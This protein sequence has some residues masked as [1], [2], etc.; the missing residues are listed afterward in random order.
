[1]ESF[2][3][4]IVQTCEAK[5]QQEYLNVLLNQCSALG[6]SK[7]PV[8]RTVELYA[9][10]T[11]S[12]SGGIPDIPECSIGCFNAT[13]TTDGCER[14]DAACHC[15]KTEAFQQSFDN[16]V[17][18]DCGVPCQQKYIDVLSG[19]CE[20]LGIALPPPPVLEPATPFPAPGSPD[21]PFNEYPDVPECSQGCFNQTITTDGCCVAD[22]ACHCSK[23]TIFTQNFLQCVVKDCPKRKDQKAYIDALL[24]SCSSVCVTVPEESQITL[25]PIP[26]ASRRARG[27]RDVSSSVS[28]FIESAS[29]GL[30]S[31]VS[32]A[33]ASAE[34]GVSSAISS[35]AATGTLNGT[36]PLL[37]VTGYSNATGAFNSSLVTSNGTAADESALTATSTTSI[38]AIAAS[39]ST[40][41]LAAMSTRTTLA[42][43]S[44][45][46]LAN[47]IVT[48][49]GVVAHGLMAMA[50]GVFAVL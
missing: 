7:P 29:S 9:S 44:S 17:K 38:D 35:I 46:G 16:C 31:A 18:K 48:G 21:C 25:P 41:S 20:A 43:S 1:M 49:N 32:S 26:S 27:R 15:T 30:I 13:V 8:P 2:E 39:S 33:T 40:F 4:C 3:S 22:A 23:T 34:S 37:N 42:T 14:T 45:S 5:D 47:L 24:D 19:E 36:L 6:I 50:G 10:P 12:P 11:P 28:N